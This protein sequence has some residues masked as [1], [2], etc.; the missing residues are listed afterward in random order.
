MR[1]IEIKARLRD[2]G[3]AE[4]VA[5][6]LGGPEPHL[7]VEQVDTYF[8]VPAGRLKLREI[9]G[10]IERAELIFYHRADQAG[11]KRSEYDVVPVTNARE[12]KAMLA[13][14]LGIRTVVR[15]QRTVYLYKNVRIHLDAVEG[16]GSFLEFEA[17]MPDG[18][19]DREG[20]DLLRSLMS[21]FAIAPGDLLES[22][23]SDLVEGQ[24]SSSAKKQR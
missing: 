21:E 4:V 17:V 24:K 22:S 10:T 9:T 14:A 23:Y 2:P 3:G 13:A 16:L 19:P 5:R 8:V 7:R 6:R 1:N 18:A 20:E 11:P 15:K 12:L